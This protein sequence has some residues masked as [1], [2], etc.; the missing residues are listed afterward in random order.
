VPVESALSQV[1]IVIRRAGRH[2]GCANS[3]E[4]L[5]QPTERLAT[6]LFDQLSVHVLVGD[7]TCG[8]LHWPFDYLDLGAVAVAR[9]D[10]DRGLIVDFLRR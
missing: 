7:K 9:D 1:D 5:L 8:A 4:R 10:F 2:Q 3:T 6:V